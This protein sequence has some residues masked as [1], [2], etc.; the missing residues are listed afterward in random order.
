MAELSERMRALVQPHLAGIEPY[1][2]NFTPTRINLSANENTYPLPD[3]VRAAIDGALAAT[4]LNRYPDPMSGALRDEL[5]AWHGVAREN[6]CV[7]NG[8]DELLY[9]FL[10]AFGGQGRTLLVC[11]PCFS[12]YEFFASLTQTSVRTVRRDRKTLRVNEKATL[13]AAQTADLVIVTSPNNPTGDALPVSFVA[14]L[15]RACPGMVM[16]DEAYIEF[17][18]AGY[19]ACGLLASCP[20][21]VILHTLSKAFGEAGIRCGYVIA[22]ADAI[23]V[24]AAVRQIYSV[25]VLTQAAALAAVQMRD[26]FVP[27]VEKIRSERERML[28]ALESDERVQAWP[29]QGNFLLVRVD[30]ASAIRRR[31]R[32][33]HSILVRDFSAVPGLEGCLRITVGTPE[34]NDEV[35]AALEAL[36]D[37]E[38]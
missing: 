13:A 33:E 11:P 16:L 26:A 10:L 9:N 14:Q 29:S 18:D 15:C 8:G 2:P 6:V 28:A 31:L 19:D 30:E 34:E 32:D 37:E 1:D 20:N 5:A 27:V 36:L 22:A 12:E 3:G 21:L 4:P 7:G 23:E 35:L 25:N 17:A 24:F 38:A